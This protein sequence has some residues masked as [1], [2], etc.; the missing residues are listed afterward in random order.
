MLEWIRQNI[1]GDRVIW[2]VVILL[3]LIGVLAVYS[4]T[5][6]F[7]Y[8]RHGGN[9]EYYLVKHL[10]I[11]VMGLFLMWLV[12]L[13]DFR[14]FARPAQFLVYPA[15]LLLI[16]T[17]VFGDDLNQARRWVTIPVIGLR[18]QSSDFAKV[19]L[20][21][22]LAHFLSKKQETIH[23][24]KKTL[25]PVLVVVTLV[26]LLIGVADLSTSV[27]LFATCFLLLF[28]GRIPFK[29]LAGLFGIGSFL[30]V[31]L[32]TVILNTDYNGGRVETW[33]NRIENY[34]SFVKEDGKSEESYQ[35]EQA[36]IAIANGGVFGVGAGKSHQRNFLPL[37][38]AD[39]IYAII[40]EEYGLVGGVIVI[41]L[42]LALLW[43]TVRIV[44]RTPK[45]FGAL[46]AI[47]L[48]FTLVIQAFMNM[49]VAVHLLPNTG[50]PLPFISMGGTSLLFTSLAIGI[51]LSV[52][53]FSGPEES[54]LEFGTKQEGGD[55]E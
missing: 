32:I 11:L 43:R 1:K 39:F 34:V 50:L 9:S 42:Y 49:G 2:V 24:F 54:N 28:I 20:V 53:R 41:L 30:M 15:I 23:D 13:V 18:F 6:S 14:Y 48:S 45:A 44:I 36:N 38:F 37:A 25:L 16:Y 22:Y 10:G 33:R 19:A 51:I 12:H 46:L 47:G 35:N 52:S 7:A 40:L 31:I 8:S 3:S 55:D 27:V 4:S 17:L 21:M 29:Y 5:E 26:C